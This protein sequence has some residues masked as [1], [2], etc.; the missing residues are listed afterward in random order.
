MVCVLTYGIKVFLKL[1]YGSNI[2]NDS[3][4]I[5]SFRMKSD[6]FL[7]NLLIQLNPQKHPLSKISNQNYTF[8]PEDNQHLFKICSFYQRFRSLRKFLK[9]IS[10]NFPY[11]TILV[12]EK[13]HFISNFMN[14][15]KSNCTFYK[16]YL[17]SFIYFLGIK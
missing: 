7:K 6:N 16:T 14:L 5:S 10:R 3:K 9:K 15:I 4:L 17:Q 13:A 2:K 8:K 1:L 12:T 11:I